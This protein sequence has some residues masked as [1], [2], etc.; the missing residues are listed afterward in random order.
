MSGLGFLKK[1]IPFFVLVFGGT[2]GLVQF[3]KVRYKYK[4]NSFT[5]ADVEDTGIKMKKKEEVTMETEFEKIKKLDV[6]T[7]ENIRGPRP[8]EENNPS[9]QKMQQRLATQ[10]SEQQL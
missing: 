8:W 9:N 10:Q 3:S 7:W 4:T 5:R 6:D 2:L 1:G